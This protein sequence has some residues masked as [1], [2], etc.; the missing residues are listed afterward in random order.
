MILSLSAEP[1]DANLDAITFST[2]VPAAGTDTINQLRFELNFEQ[3]LFELYEQ[4]LDRSYTISKSI[5]FVV[6]VPVKREIFAA[7]FRDRILHHLI[8]NYINPVVERQL[9]DDCYSCRKRIPM[10]C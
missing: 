2:N 6:T 10:L 1:V 3:N 7:D 8:F 4:L 9:I 5:A